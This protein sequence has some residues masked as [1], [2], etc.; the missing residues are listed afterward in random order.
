MF[1]FE[2]L[3]ALVIALVLSSILFGIGWEQP[4]QEHAWGGVVAWFVILLLA[5]WA[6]GAWMTPFGPR[7]WDVAWLP[8]VIIGIVLFLLLLIAVP[9]T[10]YWPRPR[11]RRGLIKQ[12]ELVREEDVVVASAFSCLFWVL[13]GLLIIALF[14][15][16]MIYPRPVRLPT[17]SSLE[18]GHEVVA[19]R[20][21]GSGSRQRQSG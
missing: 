14:S 10:K 20:A 16:Y 17:V 11:S 13:L 21:E 9:R 19:A 6:G 15:R 3:I 1:L 18:Q 8:F 2:W 4:Y 7:L 12:V 5:V